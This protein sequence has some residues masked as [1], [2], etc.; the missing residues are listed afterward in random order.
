MCGWK[1]IQT[2]NLY[3]KLGKWKQYTESTAGSA[4]ATR[5]YMCVVVTCS[6]NSG[7]LAACALVCSSNTSCAVSEEVALPCVAV[8]QW[9]SRG[10]TCYFVADEFGWLDFADAAEQ[11]AQLV[12]THALR[13]V[14]HNQVGS[15]FIVLHQ[16]F[17]KAV[18]IQLLS[19]Q[20]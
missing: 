10:V 3:K 18:V 15:C 6:F 5:K 11:T 12:L 16:L 9:Y 1:K 14:V 13:Q 17:G 2:V 19:P 20:A 4:D 7:G 8:P